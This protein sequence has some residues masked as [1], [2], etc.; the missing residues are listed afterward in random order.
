MSCFFDVRTSAQTTFAEGLRME[1]TTPK[2]SVPGTDDRHLSW[3]RPFKV[4]K[5]DP[6]SGKPFVIWIGFEALVL[7][8][9]KWKTAPYPPPT[10]IHPDRGSLERT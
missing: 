5:R 3:C 10:N 2:L 6:S 9:G 8:E 7:A 4:Q 1:G